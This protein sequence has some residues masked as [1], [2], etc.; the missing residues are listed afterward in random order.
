MEMR[1]NDNE[2]FRARLELELLK[3]GETAVALA[4]GFGVHPTVTQQGRQ[5]FLEGASGL[6]ERG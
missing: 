6:L 2:G 5:I 1:R 4:N 3:G